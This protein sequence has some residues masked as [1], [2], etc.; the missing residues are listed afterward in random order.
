VIPTPAELTAMQQPIEVVLEQYEE[1]CRHQEFL[2][3]AAEMDADGEDFEDDHYVESLPVGMRF[4]EETVAWEERVEQ[5]H[6]W[7]MRS[8]RRWKT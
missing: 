8:L 3:A 4:P 1:L 2:F 5:A 7:R 6:I